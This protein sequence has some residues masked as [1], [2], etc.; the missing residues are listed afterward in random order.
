MDVNYS[1]ASIIDGNEETSD[2][3]T[4]PSNAPEGYINIPLDKPS[5]GVTPSGQKYSYTPNDASIGDVDGDGN[6][7]IFLKWE[8]TN[9]HDNSHCGYTGNVYIDCYRLTGDKLWRIYL[10]KRRISVLELI[11]LNLWSLIW[12]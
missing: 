9:T 7:E 12:T 5:D 1:L 6:F 3:Y 8:P 10:G 4:I 2:E 11:I